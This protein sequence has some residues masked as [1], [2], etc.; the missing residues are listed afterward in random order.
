MSRGSSVK[1]PFLPP[2]TAPPPRSL[3]KS[4]QRRKQSP[5]NPLHDLNR[6]SGSSNSSDSSNVSAEASR[7]CLRFFL[8]HS[9][10]SSSS[11]SKSPACR[12]KY[13]SQTPNSIHNVPPLRKPKAKE[14]LTKGNSGEHTKNLASEKARKVKKNPPCLYQWQSGKKS[15]SKTGQKSMSSSVLN[16]HCNFL[17]RLPSGF[18]ESML[19]EERL[20]RINDNDH[21]CSLLKSC[22]NEAT[23][24]PLSKRV[25]ES[26][27]NIVRDDGDVKENSNISPSK[28]PP[29]QIS[30][31]PE[32]QCGSSL[33]S[34]T[35]PA[36]Y[37]AGYI[38][39]GVTDKRKCRPRGILIVGEDN[40]NFNYGTADSFDDGNG[41]EIMSTV[42]DVSTS[43]LPLPSEA[44]MYWVCSPHKNED[45]DATKTSE[46]GASQVQ[47]L[48][49]ST[50]LGSISPPSSSHRVSLGIIDSIDLSSAG[51]CIRRK[52][53]S[54]IS[55]SGLPEF[56][57]F[58]DSLLSPSYLPIFFSPNST[59]SCKA[60]GSGK[61][62][63][64]QHNRIEENSPYSLNSLSSG[65]VIQTPQSDFGSDIHV[66]MPWVHGDYLKKSNSKLE[67]DS[68][69][70]AIPSASFMS[71]PLG[72]S[73]NSSFQFDCSALPSDSIDLC[74]LPKFLDDQVPWLSS[75]TIDTASQSQMRISWR[76]GLMSQ[77]YEMDD[78]DCC[79]CLSDEED[80]A[81][82]CNSNDLPIRHV[83]KVNDNVDFDKKLDSDVKITETD[84]KPLRTEG[85]GKEIF[86]GLLS[87]SEAESISTDG[88]GLVAS[89]DD[90]D[91]MSCYKNTLFED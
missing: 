67:L 42:N 56:Q 84:D 39:S 51:Y 45:K 44:S 1:K 68:I 58:S 55:P 71:V 60:G 90:S 8:S 43:L 74:K 75:S 87:C 25:S 85:L 12:P 34:A 62:K 79:K 46:N 91:W 5:R 52:A 4:V 49:E 77:L 59:S 70:E 20:K 19:Q 14:N 53:S 2:A 38:V 41:N 66:G 18:G 32:I 21:K 16:N 9:S 36:C 15:G 13:L 31:S 6:I 57:G 76:E 80:L 17:P 83:P 24:T 22:H 28:T 64:F 61:G 26:D 86:P 54:S 48:A 3:A 72:D 89:R 33:V 40:P 73:I 29:I 35:T 23:L 30:V 88:T 7:G 37:G 81:N 82:D 69:G 65:N 10:S 63:T 11:S 50:T 47:V 78:F 27:L